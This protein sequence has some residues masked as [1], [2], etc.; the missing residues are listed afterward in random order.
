MDNRLAFLQTV[1]PFSELPTEVLAGVADLL[2]AVEY[3]KE[4][5]IYKQD[6]TKLRGVDLL[7]AGSYETFFYDSEQHKRLP[8][9]YGPGACY[10][11]MSILL[12][13][14]RSI[15]TV[16]ARKGTRLYFLH[17]RDFRALCLAYKDFFHYFTT[18]YGERMLNE[19]YAHF[20]RPTSA[21]EENFIAADQIYSRKIETLETRD[22][23]ECTGDTPI[24]EAAQR[25]ARGKVSC[26]FVRDAGG[27]IVGYVT[28]IV[29]RDA[30]VAKCLDARRPVADILATPIV[31]I[32]SDAFVHEA[33][34]LMFQTKTRYLLIEKGGAFVGFLSR[35]KLLS[36]LAQ[37]P[38]MFIQAVKLAQS[39]REL[40]LRWRKVPEI[41]NQLLSRGVKAELVNQVITT[42]ADTIALK[43]IEGVLAEM[44][45]AP[46]KFV[47]MVLG[48]EGRQEQTLLTDQDNAIVYEDKANEQRE[49]VR[50]YFLRFASTVSDRL[51]QIGL[52]LCTGGFIAQNPRWTH[53]LSHWKRNYHEW[54]D[55]SN[56]EAAM[57]FSTFFDC[58]LLY[59]EPEIMDEL[60]DFIRTELDRPL[61]RFLHYMATNALQ[62]EPPL[63]FFRNFRTFTQG[64]QKVF[65][66]KKTMTPIVDLVRVYALRHQVFQTNTGARLAQLRARGVFTEK[67]Y[68]ELLQAYYYLMGMRLKKQARQL[69]DDLMPATNYLDPKE[70]TQVEQVTLKEIFKVIADFQVKIKVSFTKA[71]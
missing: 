34:L 9:E 46:A 45:P 63:T 32:A 27:P 37:S 21:P 60:R 25:M 65:D 12:N 15:R 58:R 1:Q 22:L 29:L 61:D 40:R 26:L 54:I 33:I 19:E 11:G 36:D 70:L 28:D 2:Q 31:S 8:E 13:K 44:G 4:T 53:S 62:Y 57:Q 50:E 14:K 71:L 6:V 35:N 17:R 24:F 52:S 5:L 55:D 3:A 23:V 7:V 69:I 10:G 47:F 42:V 49:L 41:V 20:I 43:V 66:L 48:S 16:V 56:P 51:D 39:P 30:V 59:G 38:F 18:R 67:E 68:Q 64:D